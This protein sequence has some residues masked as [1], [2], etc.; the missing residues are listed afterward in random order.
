MAIYH[1]TVKNV[2]RRQGRSVVAAAAYR[3]G[4]RLRNERE[5]GWADFEQRSY[6]IR[7]AEI[8][9]PAG[10]PAWMGD[11]EQLWNT[12]EAIEK[13]KDARLAKEIEFALPRH[14]SA[15]AHIA[16]ARVFADH[17][18]RQG[19]VVDLAV[20]NDDGHNP[21]VHMLLT[22]RPV[23]GEGFGRK[24]RRLDSEAFIEQARRL[25]EQL[26]NAALAE[27]GSGDRIDRRSYR[28]RGLD[29]QPTVHQ[30]PTVRK[31]LVRGREPESR[32]VTYRSRWGNERVVDYREIDRG[33][34]VA[35]CEE[36]TARG[37]AAPERVPEEQRPP[38]RTAPPERA[39][40]PERPG[41]GLAGRYRQR[42]GRDAP[43]A[44]PA[45]EVTAAPE[46]QGDPAQR[47]ARAQQ[48][49][50]L[51][52]RRPV[53]EEEPERRP[54]APRPRDGASERLRDELDRLRE[55]RERDD[56]KRR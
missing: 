52:V 27:E 48:P 53:R 47:P 18:T 54:A 22:T 26:A 45:P 42:L 2:S 28:E 31:M 23:V 24:D 34:R 56:R 1:L 6:G 40:E 39:A 12:V 17:Y 8:R 15:P 10:A 55:E 35:W 44:A 36:V 32:A 11:R 5:N 3:S 13:R 41:G 33:H 37:R 16:V 9:L 7:H 20:H 51:Q 49:T 46:R 30:G 4:T 29:R 19:L 14:L 43:P 50:Q 21:H 38:E 25:W